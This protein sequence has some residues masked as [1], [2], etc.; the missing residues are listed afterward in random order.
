MI[1]YTI[2]DLKNGDYL[3]FSGI[4]LKCTTKQKAESLLDNNLVFF[5]NRKRY[6]YDI[7]K[8]EANE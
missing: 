3:K 6:E 2:L 8:I 4:L 5:Y 7:V 1:Y